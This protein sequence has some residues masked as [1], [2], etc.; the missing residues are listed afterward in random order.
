MSENV[1]LPPV[2]KAKIYVDGEMSLPWQE[3][4]RNLYSRIGGISS[5]SL[6]EI[7]NSIISE[8]LSVQS[9]NYRRIKELE[10]KIDKICE[11]KTNK[12]PD[13]KSIYN[14]V[15]GMGIINIPLPQGEEIVGRMFGLPV[16]DVIVDFSSATWNTVGTHELFTVMGG[17]V[18]CF[19]QFLCTEDL[20]GGNIQAGTAVDT[21]LCF[22]STSCSVLDAGMLWKTDATAAKSA[23][24]SVSIVEFFTT[25]DIGYGKTAAVS[26]D[27]TGIFRLWWEP[28]DVGATVVAGA[29]GSL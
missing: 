12:E 19:L 25:V 8:L 15:Y 18:H 5:M 11:I 3:F 1:F 4:F 22:P 13:L 29:G 23:L 9:S 16:I 24:A 21:D 6:L 7:T 26:T 10:D 2:P 28:V 27:G 14:M 20:V 17:E